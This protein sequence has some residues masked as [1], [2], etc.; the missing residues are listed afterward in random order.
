MADSYSKWVMT[1]AFANNLQASINSGNKIEWVSIKTSNDTHLFADLAGFNDTTLATASIKQTATINAVSI[2]GNTVTITALFNNQDNQADYYI[3]TLFLVAKYNG[4]EFLAGATV[5]NSAST[6]FRMPAASAT[7]ITEFTARPQI[8]VSNSST[9]SATVDPV[10]AA[11]NKRVDGLEA[12]LQ[13]EID[14]INADKQS[15]WNTLV[16]YVTKAGTDTITGVKTFTQTIVGSITGNAGTATK[17]QTP[18]KLKVNLASTADQTFDGSADQ[19]GIGVS[20]LLPVNSGGTG[21]AFNSSQMIETLTGITSALS[22]TLPTGL[23]G[24]A[25]TWVFTVAGSSTNGFPDNQVYTGFLIGGTGSNRFRWF[26][27]ADN[28]HTWYTAVGNYTRTG[29]TYTIDS[30]VWNKHADDSTVVHN[31]G[32]EK[33]VGN[34]TFTAGVYTN[35]GLFSKGVEVSN[36]T[37]YVDF[38]YANDTG[39]YTSRIIENT[40]G[41]LTFL[42]TAGAKMKI[43]ADLQGTADVATKLA[44]ARTIAVTGDVTGSGTFDGSGNLTITATESATTRTDTTSTQAGTDGATV[45]MIDGV[46]TN[47]A[48]EVTGVNT[49]TLTLPPTQTTVTGNAGTATKL[50][51]A[52]TIGGVSFDGTANINLP[53]VNTAGN[54]ST[55][56]NAGSATKLQTARTINGVSFDGTANISV[57]AANDASLVHTT[58]NE[59]VA[60]TKTFTSWPVVTGLNVSNGANTSG[61]VR[62]NASIPNQSDNNVPIGLNTGSTLALGG[63]EAANSYLAAMAAGSVPIGSTDATNEQLILV[64]DGYTY[65]GAGYQNGGTTGKWW[66]F[67]TDGTI[68]SPNGNLMQEVVSTTINLYGKGTY[69]VN[70][71]ATDGDYLRLIVS[72]KVVSVQGTL[73]TSVAMSGGAYL[74]EAIVPAQFAPPVARKNTVGFNAG[75]AGSKVYADVAWSIDGMLSIDNIVNGSGMTSWGT[76]PAGSVLSFADTWVIA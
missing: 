50:Q 63:G 59:T 53:G 32:D 29:D 14:D 51:T 68:T 64:S 22:F 27:M 17:L 25:R 57:N 66:A 41:Q 1:T 69:F 15:L 3:K 6:A 23:D 70:D 34:K 74:G 44:T 35:G 11:T 26:T 54:Q 56:G 33:I 9:I 30:L 46:T 21:N 58:G 45:T 52:R 18:R 5:A 43:A 75:S 13:G 28:I 10:A 55:T 4:T 24:K 2:N 39:D 20:G 73:R 37:P 36:T 31:T 49:K 62:I 67:N 48:G 16:N 60:G 71:T 61:I 19:V 72:G 47:S 8:T 40:K 38:H 42:T 12:T 76:I 65:I 7:E